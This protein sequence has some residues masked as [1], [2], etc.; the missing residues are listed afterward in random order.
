MDGISN[1]VK[2]LILLLALVIAGMCFYFFYWIKTPEYS[3]NMIVEAV[4]KHDVA[5][6]ERHVDLE[7][8]LSKGYD[9]F[10][11]Y[12][13]ADLK[14][15]EIKKAQ[16]SSWAM[17]PTFIGATKNVLN[18]YVESGKPSLEA[19]KNRGAA[20]LMKKMGL[21]A[22]DYKGTG[23]VT[24]NG[25]DA[26]VE[27]KLLNSYYNKEFV[28]KVRMAQLGDGTWQIVGIEN[29]AQYLDEASKARKEKLA[30]LNKPIKEDLATYIVAEK[31]ELEIIPWESGKGLK[32]TIP[33]TF[34]KEKTIVGILGEVVISKD[35]KEVARKIVNFQGSSHMGKTSRPI[36]VIPL[37]RLAGGDS[38][39]LSTSPDKLTSEFSIIAI[40][41]S[42]ETVIKL[43]EELPEFTMK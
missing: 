28:L 32:I 27:V 10:V 9:D 19:E 42:D 33:M 39:L 11:L 30:V 13:V 25:S 34:P 2:G 43:E 14:P 6:F 38:I 8:L 1:K 26:V 40:L 4:E 20:I 22:T 24:K 37:N 21:G 7:A 36:D 41:F 3:M 12:N 31:P 35:G 5:T 18:Q 16:V 15:E 17:K 29:L 23:A